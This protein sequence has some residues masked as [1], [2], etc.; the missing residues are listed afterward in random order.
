[1]NFDI[2]PVISPDAVSPGLYL[3]LADKDNVTISKENI[4]GLG[5][6]G[7]KQEVRIDKD[8]ELK[9]GYRLKLFIDAATLDT[10]KAEV[11]NVKDISVTYIDKGDP[12]TI[13]AIRASDLL[14]SLLKKIGLK[15]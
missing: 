8:I 2:N 9:Q 6:I 5:F 13:D 15:D 7:E 11:S 10:M 14:T 12:V 1:M 4:A 3:S